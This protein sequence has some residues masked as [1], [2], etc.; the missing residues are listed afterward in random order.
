MNKRGGII[1]YAI[2]IFIGIILGVWLTK[3]FLC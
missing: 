1:S 2:W 3:A